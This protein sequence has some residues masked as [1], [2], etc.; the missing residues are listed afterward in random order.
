MDFV[1][2][3]RNLASRIAWQ[4]GDGRSLDHW[5][6]AQ[7]AVINRL[8]GQIW[9]DEGGKPENNRRLDHW[10]A[11]EREVRIAVTAD[12]LWQKDGCWPSGGPSRRH[13]MQATSRCDPLLENVAIVAMAIALVFA[14]AI[15]EA[16]GLGP[17]ED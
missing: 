9:L 16:R 13:W 6:E 2:E 11:A 17:K 8:A 10:L 14:F 5:L 1:Q 15:A 4:R 12:Q 3:I 7:H